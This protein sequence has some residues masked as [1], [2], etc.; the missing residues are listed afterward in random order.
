M[1]RLNNYLGEVNGLKFPILMTTH[2]T[3]KTKQYGDH[4][5]YD[6]RFDFEFD[7]TRMEMP[8]SAVIDNSKDV[9]Q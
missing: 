5:I 4:V 7:E 6:Y 9:R 8:A 3:D 1:L 2:N